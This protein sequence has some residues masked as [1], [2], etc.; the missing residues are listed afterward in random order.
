DLLVEIDRGVR[1][2]HILIDITRI[3][4]LDAIYLDDAHRLHLGPLVTHNQV[5]ASELCRRYAF[6]LALACWMVGSPQSRH[7]GR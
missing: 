7:R 1:R 4:G 5:V 2:P 6:P 3:P